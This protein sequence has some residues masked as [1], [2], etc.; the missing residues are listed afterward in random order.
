[1]STHSSNLSYLPSGSDET[2]KAA[3]ADPNAFRGNKMAQL[4]TAA[5]ALRGQIDAVVA[6]NRAN[7]KTAIEGRKAELLSSVYYVSA[8]PEAQ[9]R[10]AQR[11][12][13]TLSRV[14]TE[15]Q[16][17]LLLQIGSTF[18]SSDYPALLDLLAASQQGSGDDAPPPKQTVSVK[19]IPVPGASGVL[20]SE[21]DVD[22]YL[23]ALRSALVQTLNDGKRI[24]L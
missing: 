2:V 12:D 21:E 11:I 1:L 6:T 14:A 9:Q 22:K 24:S 3:L 8:M 23:A 7:V 15:S 17:A 4:K 18:E 19:T 20:E 16:V 10:V 5:D 13:H